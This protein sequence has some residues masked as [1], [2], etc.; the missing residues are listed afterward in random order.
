MRRQS[1][2]FLYYMGII[3]NV[4]SVLL[5]DTNGVQSVVKKTTVILGVTGHRNID[6]T[7]K[8]LIKRIT[9]EIRHIKKVHKASNF[10]ILSGLAEGADRLVAQIAIKELQAQLIAVLAVPEEFFLMDFA[11]DRSKRAFKSYLKRSRTI[12]TAPLLS[13][14]AWQ[15]YTASRNNQ[16]AW[17]GAF[18][19]RHSNYLLAI[20]DGKP[21]RGRG[22]TA[23]VVRWF[24]GG[25]IPKLMLTDIIKQARKAGVKKRDKR[26]VHEFVHVKV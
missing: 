25:R 1:L 26:S 16:Y 8:A 2:C 12:I 21:A 7:D 11:D 22:G 4:L 13:K 3:R 18:I 20:W 9:T 24:K 10:V 19:A 17:I 23:E 15:D 6:M 5:L 14:K